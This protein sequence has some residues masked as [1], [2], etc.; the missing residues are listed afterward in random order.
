MVL[1]IEGTNRQ[2]WDVGELTVRRRCGLVLKFQASELGRIWGKKWRIWKRRGED[3][4]CCEDFGHC[5][6]LPPFLPPDFGHCYEA[7]VGSN[8]GRRKQM[9]RARVIQCHCWKCSYH[10]LGGAE[11]GKVGE[12]LYL[13]G[14]S[15]GAV[16]DDATEMGST[17]EAVDS[18]GEAGSGDGIG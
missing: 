16:V 3:T 5:F 13:G 4:H 9:G 14:D 15:V 11:R 12:E 2:W 6:R 17:G 1:E 8:Q 10:G 18:V 7:T